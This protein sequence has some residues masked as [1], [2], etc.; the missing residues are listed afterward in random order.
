MIENIFVNGCSFNG[1]RKKWGHSVETFVGDIVAKHFGLS[2]HNFARGGRGNRRICDTTK[3]F[4][5]KHKE[6]KT[7]TI[8]LIQWSSPGRRDYPTNDGWKPM[9]GYSTT[10]CT[11]STHEQMPFINSQ[12]GWEVFQDHSLLQLNQI[13]DLQ[14]YFK[15]NKIP[16]VMY[17]GLPN[18]INT[19][20]SD[21]K[22]LYDSIDLECFYNHNTS[23]MDFIKE[24]KLTI[25]EEDEHPS[26]LGHRIWTQDLIRLIEKK[27]FQSK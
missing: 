21:H 19:N 18:Q 24:K 4:F 26:E 14:W 13:L 9:Q 6:L 5:E 16:Y 11:W 15:A 27:Y 22:V 17:H 1:P 8:A 10:W 7:N 2:L 12:K 3:I 25:S 23:H 20:W